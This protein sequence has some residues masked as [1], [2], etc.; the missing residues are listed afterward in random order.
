MTETTAIEQNPQ[1]QI[2]A[3]MTMDIDHRARI[4]HL[5][6]ALQRIADWSAAY[7][8]AVF[9]KPDLKRAHEVLTAAGMT[10]D[11]ISAEA[12]RRVVEGVG[13]IARKALSGTEP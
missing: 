9:P 12:M 6:E 8:Y 7:P 11:A 10:L 5:E 3:L 4:Y 1:A 13:E 2:E